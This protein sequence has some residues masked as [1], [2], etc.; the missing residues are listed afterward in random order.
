MSQIGSASASDQR[1]SLNHVLHEPQG[2]TVLIHITTEQRKSRGLR[3]P[4]PFS[5][6]R[7]FRPESRL[8]AEHATVSPSGSERSRPP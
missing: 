6:K 5:I 8:L 2:L 4:T 3:R 1:L 7:T